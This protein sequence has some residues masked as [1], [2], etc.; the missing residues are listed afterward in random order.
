M[1]GTGLTNGETG[2]QFGTW[3]LAMADTS[4]TRVYFT[5]LRYFQDNVFDFDPRTVNDRLICYDYAID[6][7]CPNFPHDFVSSSWNAYTTTYATAVDPTG[8]C[9]WTLGDSGQ[10][11][12][13]DATAR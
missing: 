12:Q 6:A 8:S 3:N 5:M 7:E 4:G 1:N 10:M 13:H 2:W 11:V 9:V